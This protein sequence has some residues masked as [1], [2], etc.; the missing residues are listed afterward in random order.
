MKF[1]VFDD[2]LG[3]YG[4]DTF[5]WLQKSCAMSAIVILLTNAHSIV[6]ILDIKNILQTQ[7]R[8]TVMHLYSL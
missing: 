2:G 8:A 1:T 3:C 6:R 4:A 5:S 7:S